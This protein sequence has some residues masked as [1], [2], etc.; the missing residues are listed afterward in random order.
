MALL[1][2]PEQFDS[3][4]DAGVSLLPQVDRQHAAASLDS[5]DP[6]IEHPL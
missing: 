5:I 3:L 2:R 4:A 1:P 6:D